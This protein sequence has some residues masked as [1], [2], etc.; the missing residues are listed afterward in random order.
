MASA[1]TSSSR[2]SCQEAPGAGSPKRAAPRQAHCRSVN[3]LHRAPISCVRYAPRSRRRH[4]AVVAMASVARQAGGHNANR[5]RQLQPTNSYNILVADNLGEAGLQYLS[6]FGNVDYSPE[7]STAEL[8]A[9]V[10]LVDALIVQ[11]NI[12]V[13]SE[14]FRSAKGRLKVVGR[15]GVGV[16]NIDIQAATEVGCVVVN[17]PTANTIAAAEHSIALMCAM[18][19]CIVQADTSVK[20]GLWDRKR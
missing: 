12:K 7:L 18:T 11:D 5:E 10:S 13:T 2:C 16:D 4:S 14:V 8:C 19:R 3:W 1:P 17:A 9:K 6:E 20:Q 15:A